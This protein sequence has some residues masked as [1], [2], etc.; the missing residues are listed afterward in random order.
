MWGNRG[1]WYRLCF[2]Y[3]CYICFAFTISLLGCNKERSIPASWKEKK[4]QIASVEYESYWCQ[5]PDGSCVKPV[6]FGRICPEGCLLAPDCYSPPFPPE[7]TPT[8]VQPT[9][10]PTPI[11]TPLPTM[12]PLPPQW[13][14]GKWVDIPFGWNYLENGMAVLN[15]DGTIGIW[16]NGSKCCYHPDD[17]RFVPETMAL[18]TIGKNSRSWRILW[19]GTLPDQ[20]EQGFPKGIVIKQ[21]I[22]QGELLNAYTDKEQFLLGYSTTRTSTIGQLGRVLIGLSITELDGTPKVHT[23]DG[24]K[25]VGIDLF[26]LGWSWRDGNPI[27]W[28]REYRDGIGY[29]S[30]AFM[31]DILKGIWFNAGRSQWQLS[32]SLYMQAA[33]HLNDVVW[34]EGGLYAL[35]T[36]GGW[37]SE[38]IEEWYSVASG[39]WE[40]PGRQWQRT[41]R[42]WRAPPGEAYHSPS[43]LRLPNGRRVEPPVIVTTQ[44]L[45]GN[46]ATE[47]WYLGWIAHKD[48]RLP[49]GW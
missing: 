14:Q 8:P 24:L 17:P 26:P 15:A 10:T 12:P 2:R 4:L 22:L 35:S 13:I 29:T 1:R 36:P 7:P 38:T 19:P 48:A 47:G 44:H 43:F 32:G 46:Y 41:G 16:V 11:P 39:W 25:T 5:C 49:G 37:D 21:P 34:S 30:T 28:V 27:V 6:L 45:L 3:G 33:P 18:L 40:F 23:L 9:P 20:H 31:L 42:F